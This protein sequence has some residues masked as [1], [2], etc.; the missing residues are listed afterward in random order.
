MY[1]LDDDMKLKPFM[2]NGEKINRRQDLPKVYVLNGAVYVAES[3]FI[4]KNKSFLS[5][6]TKGY[7]MSTENSLDIDTEFD[8]AYCEWLVKRR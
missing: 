8:F 5:K 1:H 4:L 7:V 6:E 2:Q 3:E